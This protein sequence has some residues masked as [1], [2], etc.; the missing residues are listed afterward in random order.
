M[1]WGQSYSD[2]IVDAT[3]VARGNRGPGQT[4]VEHGKFLEPEESQLRAWQGAEPEPTGI[5]PAL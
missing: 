4:W 1:A 2:P 3:A 5:P